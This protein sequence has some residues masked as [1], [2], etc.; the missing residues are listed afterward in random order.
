M[1]AN[2]QKAITSRIRKRGYTKTDFLAA[3]AVA[4]AIEAQLQTAALNADALWTREWLQMTAKTIATTRRV[5]RR[6]ERQH[7]ATT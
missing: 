2:D 5:V 4:R 7:R 3:R 1:D 6:M